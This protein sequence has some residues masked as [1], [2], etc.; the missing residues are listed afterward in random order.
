MFFLSAV[1]LPSHQHVVK[2]QAPLDHNNIPY[3]LSLQ[4]V[5]ALVV[6][7]SMYLLFYSF[8]KAVEILALTS[9]RH[10]MFCIAAAARHSLASVQTPK[11]FLASRWLLL[12]LV[13]ARW[14]RTVM[15]HGM[16]RLLVQHYLS[17]FTI[18]FISFLLLTSM[19]QNRSNL[20]VRLPFYH[21]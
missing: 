4:L 19:V 12:Y 7:S 17:H 6:W 21:V 13:S 8:Q 9:I 1:K 20:Q 14:P 2:V 16:I 3:G 11:A 15:Y 5:F 18:E 10:C